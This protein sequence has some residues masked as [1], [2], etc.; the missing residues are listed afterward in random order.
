MDACVLHPTRE[1]NCN[2]SVLIAAVMLNTCSDLVGDVTVGSILNAI[3]F[4]TLCSETVLV[5]LGIV[6]RP[7]ES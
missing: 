6:G 1:V 5:A 4:L 7:K 2:L 3:F